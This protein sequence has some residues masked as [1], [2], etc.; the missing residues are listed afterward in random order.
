MYVCKFD[1]HNDCGKGD[2]TY[3]ICHVTLQDHVIKGLY[4]YGNKLLTACNHHANFDGHR[5]CGSGAIMFLIY[6]VSSCDHVFKRL[7]HVMSGSFS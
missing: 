1:G 2:I 7:C 6:H 3:L 5:H 4:D